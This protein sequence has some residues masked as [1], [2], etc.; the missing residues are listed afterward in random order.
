[1]PP[2]KLT[3]RSAPIRKLPPRKQSSERQTVRL[4][5]FLLQ[6]DTRPSA[7][8][9]VAVIFGKDHYRRRL[10]TLKTQHEAESYRDQ[11]QKEMNKR[12]Y[13]AWLEAH[14]PKLGRPKSAEGPK[15]KAQQ[16]DTQQELVG[17]GNDPPATATIDA[18]QPS[19]VRT[20]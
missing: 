14:P 13:Q 17:N 8:P 20:F 16:V 2:S 9:T 19:Q 15:H 18:A 12:G 6:K 10:K 5:D 7:E 3:V 11:V 1:M 4:E